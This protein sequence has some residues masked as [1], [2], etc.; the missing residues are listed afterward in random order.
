MALVM[1][2]ASISGIALLP[3]DISVAARVAL[4]T[5]ALS[6][7]GWTLTKLNDT[8]V[9]LF[10]ATGLVL[11]ATIS[12][13]NFFASLGNSIVWLMIG[14]FI[15]SNALNKSGVSARI[16]ALAAKPAKNVSHL[17][18]LLT[19]VLL[20]TALLIP[21]TSARAALMVPIYAAMSAAFNDPK[22]NRALAIMLPV[23]ILQ[24]AI[25]SLVGAG[26]HLIINDT[27]GQFTG[28][29]LSFVEWTVMG[30]PFAALSAFATTWIILHFFL[31][32]QRRHLPLN[33][34]SLTALPQPGPITV[35]ERFVLAVT[36]VL[37]LLWMT[38]PLH[39]MS[40]ALVAMLGALAVT[41]PA[42][43]PVKFKDAAKGV[44][45][46]MILFVAAT[47]AL[48]EALVQSGAG[49]WLV[50][51]LLAVSGVASATS[52]LATLGAVT[53]V[54]LTSHLYIT[55]RSARGAVI[56]PLTVLLAFTLGL[57][58]LTLAFVTAA[59]IGY[60]ITLVVSAKPLTMFQQMNGPDTAPAFHP[61]DLVKLSGV[62]A[63]LHVG[64]IVLFGWFYWPS[65]AQA[66]HI[67]PPAPATVGEAQARVDAAPVGL[68]VAGLS[69]GVFV[70][71]SALAN[72]GLVVRD[73]EVTVKNTS[74]SPACTCGPSGSGNGTAP[75][76]APAV[77]PL[78]PSFGVAPTLAA[79]TAAPVTPA[80][81]EPT[82]IPAPAT[83]ATAVPDPG[84]DDDDDDDAD[85]AE[86]TAVASPSPTPQ[87]NDEGDDGGKEDEEDAGSDNAQSL[88]ARQPKPTAT[89]QS[90]DDD[91]DS[92][93][94]A[95]APTS[96]P[97]TQPEPTAL[98]PSDE[99]D[100]DAA[101]D[102]QGGGS[103]GGS[104]T[105]AAP[106][107]ALPPPPTP[108][109]PADSDGESGGGSDGNGGG[110]SGDDD[111]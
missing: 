21:S 40:N 55:S 104:S 23:N 95:P 99:D 9:A 31:D 8:F 92:R 111:D 33:A 14:A 19:A 54:T 98:P 61:S 11:S 45:W 24:T 105:H 81:P 43:G 73:G 35:Q 68:G 60:C 107:P 34:H 15:V 5:F 59:G 64:L 108:A 71:E 42:Y 27:L 7:I 65:F 93:E 16:T 76:G 52:K 89:P 72:A 70:R 90:S 41:A 69:G 56:A 28:R 48:S 63:P 106:A 66:A 13:E 38:E 1:A 85:V 47:L 36:A 110:G 67:A 3:A 103:G 18:Y 97:S 77:A 87:S 26:A 20:L 88:P 12:T 96:A 10:A 2:L 44:E 62:L 4:A 50:D 101:N 53:V 80:T 100:E 74:Q 17:F 58:P 6:V 94:E 102:A 29:P 25:G 22:I 109:P 78:A 91:Q 46:E 37:V 79:A 86:P 83:T 39:G 32:K 30:L 82:S 49:K 51:R 75:Q 84:N 57:D